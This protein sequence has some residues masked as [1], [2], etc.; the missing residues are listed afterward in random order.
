MNITRFSIKR[1]IG[2]CM[3]YILVCVLGLISFFRIGVELL[4]D[5]DSKFISVIVNYPGASTESVE[6]QVTK[7]IEDEL[8]SIS[9]FKQVRS[10]TRPGRAEIFVE[11]DSQADADMVAI[12]ATKKVSRIRKN[13]PEDIDEPAVLK[14]SSEEYPIIQIAATSKDNLDDIFALADS[15]FKERLQ[16]AAGVADVDVTGGR[17]KEIA[18]EVD[19]D[20][21]NYYGLTLQDIIT[22]V[23]KENVIVSSGSVYTDALEKTVRLQAQYKAP[24]EIQHLQLKGTGGRYIELGQVANV[25]AKDKRAVAYSRVDGNEA[26]SLEVY[27]ASGANIVDTADGVLQ[28]LETLRKDYPD[29]VFTVVYDQSHF[30]RDSLS[31]TLKTLLEGLV[32]TGLVLYLFLRGWKSSMA[33]M[34]AIPTSLIATF[35]LM[36][37]AGFTFNMMSLMGMALCIGILVDDSIVVLENIHRFLAMGKSADVAAEEGR[38]EIGMAA[39]AMTLC[40]VVVFLPIAFMQ[41]ATGQFFKQFGLTVAFA[42]AFSTIVAFSLTPMVSA[43]WIKAE[44]EEQSSKERTHF[45]QRALDKFEAGFQSVRE[46]YDSLMAWALERPKKVVAV[47]IISLL[48]NLLLL[49][50]VG[51]EFQP[52][53]DSGEFSVNVKAPIGTSLQKTVELAK[54]LQQE[55]SQLPEVKIV[56]LNIGNGRNPVNQGSLDIRLKP[57]NER[58]RSMQQIMDDLRGRFQNVEGLKVTVVSNQGGGRGDS[59]PVQI[60]LRGSNIKELKNYA[61][62]LADMIRQTEGATDVDI[63]DSEEQPEIVVKLDHA[64]ASEFGLDATEV[65]K[66]IEMAIMGKSTSNSYTIGDNDYDIILQL[67]QSQRTNINDVM[68][69]RISSSSGQF[70]RLGD[71]ADVRYGSGPT[72]IER[73]DKQRQIVVYANTVGI[74]PGDLISKVRNEYIPELNLPPGY[75]YKMIGQ[76]DNMARSFK[77]VYK[78]VILAIVV[79]YMVLAAQFESFSQ[80]LIIMVSLPFAIIGAIL[81][82]LVAGQTANMMSMIGFTMLLGLVTKNAILLIDYANQ[83]REKGMSIREAVLL[84]CSLRLRPILMTS[85]AFILGCLPLAI[86]TGPGAGARVSMGNAVVGGMTIATLFGIFLIPVLFVVVERFFSRKKKGTPEDNVTEQL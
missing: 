24:E 21:L 61:Q 73:E 1:P 43:Y 59:R 69:L 75:N 30:V 7:P 12:E 40:D 36:Y 31:N 84:A 17:A 38:N 11:L 71:I 51:T 5:V 60:G 19:K 29:Y 23:R 81:G 2:I 44:T 65:G 85:F 79:V 67:E 32:T 52:T 13:L 14:R 18:I 22:A 70:I 48:L 28:Q 9:H 86:A 27:K 76:A 15:S 56:A 50:F 39:I 78:A 72:R 83:E 55:I 46:M 58:E 6:Q 35:F 80:P 34:I 82:L 62:Q 41:S 74:S 68:N 49:P 20:K 37:L 45:V 66:V 53:Y 26:V 54:P 16:Q 42:V 10:A 8:S 64:K 77:E 4:P 3:I 63:S 57:S 33:V 25:Q 47:G